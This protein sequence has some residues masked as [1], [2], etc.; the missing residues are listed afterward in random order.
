[1]KVHVLSASLRLENAQQVHVIL[2]LL[3]HTT[4]AHRT[5]Y[6]SVDAALHGP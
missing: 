6:T 3:C 4:I 1:M 2:L 5:S